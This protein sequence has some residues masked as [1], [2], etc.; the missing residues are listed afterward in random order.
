MDSRCALSAS[1]LCGLKPER[2][3]RCELPASDVWGTRLDSDSRCELSASHLRGFK[4]GKDSRCELS[5][6]NVWGSIGHS[7]QGTICDSAH[8]VSTICG[9][10]DDSLKPM[11]PVFGENPGL[12]HCPVLPVFEQVSRSVL[13][14][15]KKAFF[16]LNFVQGRPNCQQLVL[17]LALQQLQ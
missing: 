14:P 6:S 16:L 1:H 17:G 5:A 10:F 7:P 8:D 3:S 13:K 12:D 2:G 11:K 15:L 4:S 9:S